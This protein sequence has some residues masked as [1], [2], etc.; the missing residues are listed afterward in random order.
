MSSRSVSPGGIGSKT[1]I[2][3]LQKNCS[4]PTAA[5]HKVVYL[6]AGP[7]IKYFEKIFFKEE[8]TRNKILVMFAFIMNDSVCAK[9]GA[10]GHLERHTFKSKPLCK[11]LPTAEKLTVA[12][13]AEREIFCKRMFGVRLRHSL[14]ELQQIASEESLKFW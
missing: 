3:F 14:E 4:W 2:S 6:N 5:V 11:F 13:M 8:L 12:D 1:E 10:T 9:C 7:V